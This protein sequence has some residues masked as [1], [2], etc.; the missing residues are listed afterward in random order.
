MARFGVHA[1][2]DMRVRNRKLSWALRLETLRRQHLR[3]KEKELR[4]KRQP[5]ALPLPETEDD[6][7]ENTQQPRR[8]K[9]H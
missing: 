4:E 1:G 3:D 6:E 7:V 9:L 2:R 5:T 8:S